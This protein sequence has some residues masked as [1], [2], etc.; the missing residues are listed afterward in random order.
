MR[1]CANAR[2]RE[3]ANARMSECANA[4]F[5]AVACVAAGITANPIHSFT[6]AGH[7]LISFA[8]SPIR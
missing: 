7:S 8:N 5:V 3:C 1:E 4:R 6:H 2:M